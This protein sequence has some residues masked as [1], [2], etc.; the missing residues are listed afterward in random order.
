MKAIRVFAFIFVAVVA[1]RAQDPF[2]GTEAVLMPAQHHEQNPSVPPL[3]LAQLEQ[4]ALQANPE[5]RLAVRQLSIAQARVTAAGALDDPSFMYRGWGVPLRQ[6]WDLNQAQN[7]F[8]FTQ[9][10]PGPGKRG[11]RS[12]V[13]EQEVSMAKATLD[14]KRLEVL[15]KVRN[16]YY[17]L[18]LN[19]DELRIHDEQI[20][21]ARQG[22]QAA[23]IK[24]TVGNVP[25]QDVLKAQI[26]L[27]RLADHLIMLRQ[28]GQLARA[29]L[30]TLI[31]RD[32]AAP[33][34]VDG[35]YKPL[36]VLPSV[37]ELENLAVAHRPEISGAT[38]GIEEGESA[39]KLARKAYT[40]DYTASGGYMLMPGTSAVRNTYMAEF[41]LNLPWLNRRRHNSEIDEATAKLDT[42]QAQY[43]L[44]RSIVFQ[45]IQEALVRAQAARDLLDLY[46]N[47]LRPQAQATLRATVTAYENNRTDFLNLLD[48]QNATVDVET[49]Y[50]QAA[51]DFEARLADLELAVGA[52]IQRETQSGTK[53][54]GQ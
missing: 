16:A 34:E 32:P 2:A 30:N 38:V 3:M 45:Q 8:M 27:T 37:A 15:A 22:L 7:M 29:T 23:R 36:G 13:A 6:P 12:S 52:P 44:Q 14:A 31:G 9:S 48:S 51:S 19:R 47:T 50:A 5:I 49:S 21:I 20:A 46:G 18:L 35:E 10:F 40:P 43:E 41:S 53:E 25:Q 26:A 42:A 28:T 1:S 4:Q 11:L 33:I 39:L 24:Y 54:G 17:D